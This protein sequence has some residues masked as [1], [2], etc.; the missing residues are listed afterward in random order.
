MLK[1]KNMISTRSGRVVANQFNISRY[2][3]TGRAEEHVF[4]SYASECA[5]LKRTENGLYKLTIYRD[6]F[7]SRT[8][9]KYLR[10]WLNDHIN[11]ERVPDVLKAAK[12]AIN[13]GAEKWE[14]E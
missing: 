8:T 4:Q 7:Y 6:G 13:A 12:E 3:E 2:D 1:V 9:A 5:S 11:P 10:T 14:V